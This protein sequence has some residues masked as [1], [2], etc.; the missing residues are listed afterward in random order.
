MD[1]LTRHPPAEEPKIPTSIGSGS[2]ATVYSLRGIPFVFKV[3]HLPD[4]S[5]ELRAEFHAL[6]TLYTLCTSNSMF[7]IPRAIAFYDPA[8]KELIKFSPSPAIGRVRG[9]RPI[10]DSGLFINENFDAPAHIMDRAHVLPTQIRSFIRD[11]FYNTLARSQN[12]EPLRT[13]R[14][15]FGKVL[16]PSQFDSINFPIDAARY[17]FLLNHFNRGEL[18]GLNEVAGGMSEMLGRIHWIAGYDGRDIEFVRA[19]SGMGV[20]YYVL[21]FNQ[22]SR[23]PQE[24]W[25]SNIRS[26]VDAFFS[27]DPYYPRPVPQDR[28]YQAF[29]A[30]YLVAC[31][32]EYET[33]AHTFLNGI[34]AEQAKTSLG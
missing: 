25:Q 17:T 14:L 32:G 30:A 23:C 20:R 24:L 15:Y 33:G 6:Q 27:N 13:C 12:V 8:S 9:P 5:D 22:M 16:C 7:A 10:V 29:R 31:P 26:L 28:L 3:T 4:R 19:G 2:F 11:S 1:H 34:E 18:L 21:D